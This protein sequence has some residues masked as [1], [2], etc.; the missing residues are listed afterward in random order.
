[1]AS[2]TQ[3][4]S[5]QEVLPLK[6]L[7]S[8]R[9]TGKTWAVGGG[10]TAPLTK[11]NEL[12]ITSGSGVLANL[13]GSGGA[14]L[15]T[16]AEY[17]DVDIELD[18]LM[19][20]GSNSGIYLQGRYEVQLA[21]SWGNKSATPGDNGGVYQRW[22][23]SRPAGQ[24]GY[25]G[26]APRQNVS[27]APGLWQHIRIS[28]QA[29]RF[30]ASGRKLESA[31]LLRVELN[32]VL[33]HEDVELSGP[34]RGAIENNEKPIGPLRL[35]GDHGPVA[36]RN[37]K[38]TSF[39]KPRPRFSNVK[40]TVYRGRFYDTLDL[41]KLPPEAQG[42]LD[43]LSATSIQNLPSQFFIKYTGTVTIT[44]PGEYNFN[45]GVPGGRGIMRI[46]SQLPVQQ[47]RGQRAGFNLP[48]GEAP[49]E[50]LYAKNQD[51]TNRSLV[52]SV[53]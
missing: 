53:N 1:M 35:Q 5:A 10:V 31:K 37:I 52:L 49:F 29:P 41:K 15:F 45:V 46:N 14:D 51:W 39:D 50:L 32:D 17:G 47:G 44:E 36:F 42:T 43:N 40:Y 38:I 21:D 4:V 30:D 34:T 19:A 33:I 24:F 22:D 8:F 11:A 6:D 26:H 9:T 12:A 13:P 27:K 2:V 23:E 3:T 18:Y 7:S 20:K 28:F 16:L 25:E 48:A